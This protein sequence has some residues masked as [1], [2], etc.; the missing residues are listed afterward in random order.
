MTVS[1]P[2][3]VPCPL[4]LSDVQAYIRSKSDDDVVGTQGLPASTL[5]AETW[6]FRH[7]IANM[8]V[9]RPTG[10]LEVGQTRYELSEEL[11][12]IHLLFE[13]LMQWHD[14]RIAKK[15]WVSYAK[16]HWAKMREVAKA[17]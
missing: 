13:R 14:S 4:N 6:Y 12:A 9:V 5:I 15:T 16:Q 1:N 10:V 17:S 7:G 8:A 2:P 3:V 11:W